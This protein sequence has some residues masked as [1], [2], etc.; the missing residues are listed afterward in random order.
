[1]MRNLIYSSILLSAFATVS[2]HASPL[3][4]GNIL[5]EG[6]AGCSLGIAVSVTGILWMTIHS[7]PSG[8]VSIGRTNIL[9]YCISGAIV[10]MSIHGITKLSD[11]YE[12]Y[13]HPHSIADK[14]LQMIYPQTPGWEY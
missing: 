14:N 11:M 8:P 5:A 3:T 4:R 13:Q 9:T 12:E 6:F 2:A 10:A 1:M 7:Q